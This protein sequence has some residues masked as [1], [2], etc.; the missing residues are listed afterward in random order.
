MFL[1]VIIMS[2]EQILLDYQSIEPNLKNYAFSS[3]QC[4]QDVEDVLQSAILKAYLHRDLLTTAFFSQWMFRVVRNECI[5]IVRRRKK[6]ATLSDACLN[7][8]ESER[9][10]SPIEYVVYK[11]MLQRLPNTCKEAALLHF[12]Y[13]YCSKVIAGII[14]CSDTTVRNR[15]FKAR[16]FLR[17][18]A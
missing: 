10:L 12:G 2:D 14:N 15:I 7:V 5:D 9:Y 13:G 11:D 17:Q 3:L 8:M 4:S 6:Y 18:L 16:K 1:K